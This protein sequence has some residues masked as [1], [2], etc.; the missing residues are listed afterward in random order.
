MSE[1]NRSAPLALYEYALFAACTA[2]IAW[3]LFI[4]PALGIA[5]NS[6]FGKLS[7]RLCIGGDHLQF[8]YAALGYLRGPAYC[9]NAGLLTSAE[10]PLRIATAA[11]KPFAANRFDLRWLG[12]VYGMLFLGAVVVVQKLTRTLSDAARLIVPASVCIVFC[13]ATYV[14]WFNTF[15][16]D[17]A[18]YVFL[19]F[20]IPALLGLILHETV[21]TRACLW[22]LAATLLFETSKS[23]HTALAL[24]LI[25]CFWLRFGRTTFPRLPLRILST[26]AIIAAAALMFTT[27]PKWYQTVNSY[28]AL[29]YQ[30]L[31]HS[32]DPVADLAQ[33]GMEPAMARY[34]G[35][36][37]FLPDSFLNDA[38]ETERLGHFLS[39]RNLTIYYLSHPRI[40][41]L[42]FRNVLAEGSLQRVEMQI[43]KRQY[44]LGNYEMSAGKPP[45]AQSHFF[46]FWT[47][48]K[49]AAF[50]N[51]P[52][53]YG[54]Y[55]V[56]LVAGLW[57]LALR[58]SARFVAIAAMWTSML[59]IAAV[60]VM[61]DGIDTG[62]H[63]FLF[64]AM[65]DMTVCGLLCF[66]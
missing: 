64:N 14:P 60:L 17:T 5:D 1:A 8:E 44:R 32:P 57:I 53:L 30:A 20:T 37:A 23:Q 35:K 38:R 34:V 56:A 55:I 43:G 24:P 39:A 18:S 15:Y 21:T 58:R 22:A 3:Q 41:G 33:F 6:D 52:L 62:R 47:C 9:Y 12:A 45:E 26:V 29:F 4:P 25:P 49:T 48:L 27:T 28:N 66:I 7:G 59:A 50:G 19:C 42:V 51:R 13:S 16:F 40:A 46:D 10:L 65:L 61:F 2:L 36:H 11:S 63:M 31:P 54:F